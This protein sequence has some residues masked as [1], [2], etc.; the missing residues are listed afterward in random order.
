MVSPDRLGETALQ[1]R[2]L[3]LELEPL[4]RF[5]G[6]RVNLGKPLG[7]DLRS[8]TQIAVL[9]VALFGY[10]AADLFLFRL[11]ELCNREDVGVATALDDIFG[12]P[13]ELLEELLVVGNNH[14]PRSQ[15]DRAEPAKVPPG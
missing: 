1:G 6:L 8:F 7:E 3:A 12:D 14:R 15:R 11:G 2:Q 10:P 5:H 13:L 4:E 9:L